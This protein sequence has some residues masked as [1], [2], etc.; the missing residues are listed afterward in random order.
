MLEL[1]EH[2]NAAS[3]VGEDGKPQE[4]SIAYREF[5]ALVGDILIEPI[6][7]DPVREVSDRALV[8]EFGDGSGD[9][10]V[11]WSRSLRIP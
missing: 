7:L 1:V 10:D 3:P 5:K 6:S 2:L 4:A 9:C 11:F 8:S